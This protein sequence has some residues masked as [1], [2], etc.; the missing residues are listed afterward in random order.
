MDVCFEGIGQV[1]AT[2]RTEAELTPGMAVTIS[3]NGVV[4]LG[5]ATSL[6]CGVTVGTVRGGAV[7][8]Q[9]AGV[10]KVGYTGSTAPKA[11]WAGLT[12]DGKGGVSAA[13]SGGLNCLVLAVDEVEKT[14]VIKL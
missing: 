14:A 10:V 7:A 6:P 12:C 3:G 9:I 5:T 4:D 2:F 13:G 11:G 8:V 1:V